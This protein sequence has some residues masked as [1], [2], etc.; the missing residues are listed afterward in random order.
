DAAGVRLAADLVD[1][2]D[3]FFAAIESS[4]DFR[5]GREFR[6]RAPEFVSDTITGHL[7]ALQ[8]RISEVARRADD[9][10]LKAELQELGRRICDARDGTVIFL[11]QNAR[12]HVD[13]VE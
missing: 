4:C 10:F 13:W 5:K 11:E 7:A 9:E 8:A 2:L 12:E 1:E 6:V 3:R